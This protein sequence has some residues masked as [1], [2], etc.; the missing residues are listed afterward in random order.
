MGA[1]SFVKPG[2]FVHLMEAEV[3][4]GLPIVLNITWAEGSATL[5]EAGGL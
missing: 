4:A 5:T 3:Y 2:A 1:P